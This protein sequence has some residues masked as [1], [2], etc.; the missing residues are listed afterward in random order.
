MEND[1]LLRSIGYPKLTGQA[2]DGVIS[3]LI[4]KHPILILCNGLG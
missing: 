2:V 4:F 1:D 3:R